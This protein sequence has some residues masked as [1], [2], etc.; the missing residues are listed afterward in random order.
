MCT[1]FCWYLITVKERGIA[2]ITSPA[3]RLGAAKAF[4]SRL[5]DAPTIIASHLLWLTIILDAYLVD[6]LALKEV[7]TH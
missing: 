4:N 5:L 2:A 7:M 1:A 3:K 6:L